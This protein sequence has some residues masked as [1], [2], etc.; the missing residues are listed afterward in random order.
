MFRN[1]RSRSTLFTSVL[2]IGCAADHPERA[3][4]A[5]EQQR[6]EQTVLTDIARSGIVRVTPWP[7]QLQFGR[8]GTLA[9]ESAWE[10]FLSDDHTQIAVR[11]NVGTVRLLATDTLKEVAELAAPAG[12][13]E[14]LRFSPDGR[15]LAT[16]S[17]ESGQVVVW[18]TTDAFVVHL[19]QR[20]S[21]RLQEHF[22][23]GLAFSSDGKKVATYFGDII[24]LASGATAVWMIEFNVRDLHF[25]GNDRYLLAFGSIRQGSSITGYVSLHD[26][27]Q[28][29]MLWKLAN[30]PAVLSQDGRTLVHGDHAKVVYDLTQVPPRGEPLAVAGSPIGISPDGSHVYLRD[31]ADVVAYAFA[32]K[33]TGAR[34][35]VPWNASVLGVSPA[36]ELVVS[37]DKETRWFDSASGAV[38]RMLPERFRKIHWSADGAIRAASGDASLL[39][40][41]RETDGVLVAQ[42]PARPV[43]LPSLH[44]RGNVRERVREELLP[45]E[46]RFVAVSADESLSLYMERDPPRNYELVAYDRDRNILRTF[47]SNLPVGYPGM[48]SSAELTA[49]G[50]VMITVEADGV[51]PTHPYLPIWCR[52]RS[53]A[54][55]APRTAG[56]PRADEKIGAFDVELVGTGLKSYTSIHGA[57]S[58]APLPVAS[59]ASDVMDGC[60]IQ[61]PRAHT[62]SPACAPSAVCV[63]DGVCKPLPALLDVGT[64]TVQGVR[65]E[66]G[67]ARFTMSPTEPRIYIQP[68]DRALAFPAFGEGDRITVTTSGG[69]LAPF[70]LEG[71]GLAPL[72][73]PQAMPTVQRGL[74]F[75]VR[76]TAPQAVSDA[77]VRVEIDLS[78][79]RGPQHL[80]VCEG[81]DT[82]ELTIPAERMKELVDFGLSGHPSMKLTRV[83]TTS[84]RAERGRVDLRVSAT[85]EVAINLEGLY[86]CTRTPSGCGYRS[87][88]ARCRPDHLC[89]NTFEADGRETPNGP[90]SFADYVRSTA[91]S[92]R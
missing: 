70:T 38:V 42:V 53:P 7:A 30:G 26:V 69:A 67:E 44:G 45:F 77:R 87:A 9:G 58:A 41:E 79:W 25:V 91:M 74:P 85:R 16:V 84:T 22:P 61:T 82:G 46:K 36:D 2:L 88:L 51:E 31:R 37:T 78:P 52:T 47:S 14:N 8:C 60:A 62:C 83:R 43:V 72:E 32:T 12:P 48:A 40:I 11:T 20:P 50:K 34:F 5:A 13:I 27:A 10:P 1:T 17:R 28:G 23:S 24:D 76:W 33:A 18:R 68:G 71:S 80:L 66:R 89:E 29:T 6:G 86:S 92:P 3:T 19:Q 73:L 39:R 81:K 56:G 15:L 65:D 4:P 54:D 75:V 59:A 63:D 57:V 21:G 64:V 90:T 35:P 55:D 49:D